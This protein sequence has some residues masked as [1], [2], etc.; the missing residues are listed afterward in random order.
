MSPNTDQFCTDMIRPASCDGL[1]AIKH[2][3]RLFFV[4]YKNGNVVAKNG[5]T[6]EITLKSKTGHEY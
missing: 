6:N 1:N 3:E 2:C 5:Q 4:E